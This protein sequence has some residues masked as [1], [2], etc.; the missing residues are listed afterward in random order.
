MKGCAGG[1][2]RGP[3][4]R[5]H[6]EVERRGPHLR[7]RGG[8]GLRRAFEVLSQTRLVPGTESRR[9][10]EGAPFHVFTVARTTDAVTVTGGLVV[11]PRHSFEDAPSICWWCPGGSA[12]V[13]SCRRRRPSTGFD[14]PRRPLARLPPSALGRFSSRE[15]GCSTRVA[16]PRTG[17]RSACWAHSATTS[18]WTASRGSWRTGS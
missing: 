6:G 12:P 8:A 2:E 9:S 13:R 5:R 15:L 18:R 17:G 4:R 14:T 7:W 3:V 1:S 16:P 10:D 11:L